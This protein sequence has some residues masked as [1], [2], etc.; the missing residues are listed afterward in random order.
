MNIFS[1]PGRIEFKAGFLFI[2]RFGSA[3]KE[4]ASRRSGSLI[5]SHVD[6]WSK[7]YSDNSCAFV[8]PAESLTETFSFLPE[9]LGKRL[10]QRRVWRRRFGET[11][12]RK[13]D[14]KRAS[15]TASL[16]TT[17]Q[18]PQRRME[19][20]T[21]DVPLR[22]RPTQAHPTVE[23]PPYKDQQ[24]F[25][26]KHLHSQLRKGQEW[27]LLDVRWFKQWKKY[28]AFDVWDTDGAGE[29]SSHP[30]PIDSSSLYESN[31]TTLRS[32]L[33]DELDYMLVPRAGMEQTTGLV[34]PG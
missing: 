17:G 24:E 32:G 27:Y 3:K 26:K 20:K 19:M 10:L 31:T 22:K 13:L 12:I 34:W 8:T 9:R 29:S 2:L 21:S 4:A 23:A 25:V 6:T 7:A 11:M 18:T 15:P 1:L 14:E 33:I 30:G 28:V 5:I 16:S